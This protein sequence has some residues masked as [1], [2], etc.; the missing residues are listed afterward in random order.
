MYLTENNKVFV[1]LAIEIVC[2]YTEALF[3]LDGHQTYLNLLSIVKRHEFLY[4][5]KAYPC[6]I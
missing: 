2:F 5:C 6:F 4:T 3:S 1:A